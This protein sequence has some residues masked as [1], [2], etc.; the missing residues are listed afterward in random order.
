MSIV[1]IIDLSPLFFSFQTEEERADAEAAVARRVGAAARDVGFFVVTGHGVDKNVVD[2]AWIAVR[3][4]FDLELEEKMH[5]T[6]PQ[7]VNPF[8]YSPLGEEILS[9]G[10]ASENNTNNDLASPDLKEM[11]SVGPEDPRAGFP[12]R[13][14]PSN[15]PS[16]ATALPAY[17]N[18][19]NDLAKRILRCFAIALE[20]EDVDFFEKFCDKHASA[21]RAIN[22]PEIPDNKRILPGQLR[23]SAHTDYGT[24]T[25]LRADGPGLQ[26]SKDV[27]SPNWHDV[28]VV[29]D[30]FIVNLG[31]LMRRWTNDL[32]LSTLHRV[33][34]P[35][36]ENS[37][38][39]R[40]SIAFFHNINRDAEVKVLLRN[41]DDV[42]KHP[43]II[44]GDFLMQKHLAS[45]GKRA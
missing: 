33:V 22:Y 41:A 42:P 24:I 11:Y 40:Q 16:F 31:D 13:V 43:P 2:E 30:C 25:I 8:G 15:P 6:M 19:L 36:D 20:L 27:A 37:T 45:L 5:F 28:P 14:L 23:A 7:E 38:R 17:Y 1:P 12:P 44:A 35:L 10:K 9:S 32:W 26:V 39:R 21:L 3:T 29:E 4:F 34:V 18:C